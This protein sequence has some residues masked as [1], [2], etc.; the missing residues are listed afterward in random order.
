MGEVA[1]KETTESPPDLFMI[2]RLLRDT[3]GFQMLG[4]F[5]QH[6]KTQSVPIIMMSG[7]A[8]NANQMA[9]ARGM[10]ANEYLVKPLDLTDVSSKVDRLLSTMPQR[11]VDSA[12]EPIQESA[13]ETVSE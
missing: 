5:R 12:P 4:R 2:D 11:T 13:P 10:G 6:A 8:K 9:I 7:T 3:T 1:F